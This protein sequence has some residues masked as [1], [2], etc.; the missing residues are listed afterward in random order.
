[1]GLKL[2]NIRLTIDGQEVEVEKGTTVLEAAQQAGIYI[3]TLCHHPDLE[4]YGG[5]R[6]CVI[7]IEGIRG[8]PTACTTPATDGMVVRTNSP[9]IDQVRRTALELMLTEHPHACL[10]CHRREYC[11]P[12]DI[13]LRNVAVTERCV[14]CP[15][16]GHCELQN[17]AR[18]IKLDDIRLPY[19]PKE[20]PVKTDDPLFIRDYNL[21][22]MCARCVRMCQEVR[23]TGAIDLAYRGFQSIVS[24]PFDRPLIDSGCKFCLACVEVCPTA[25]LRDKGAEGLSEAEREAFLVPCKHACP[26]EIDIPRFIRLISERRFADALAVIAEKTPF[27]L[28]CGTVCHHPCEAKCRRG[29]VNE[30]IA[31]RV[32][33]RFLAE[34]A[35]IGGVRRIKLVPPS[36]KRVAIVGAGPAGLT[37]AYYLS[38]L[39]GH[40]ITVLEELPEAGGMLRYGIPEYRLPKKALDSE[41]SLLRDSGVEIRTNTR[42]DSLDELFAQGYDAVFLALG[43]HRGTRLGVE[44]EDSPGVIDGVTF[45]R[46]VNSGEK[47]DVRDKVAVIGGGNVAMDSARTVLRLGAKEVNI[48]YRRTMSEMPASPEEVEG[49]KEEGINMVLLANPIRISRQNGRLQVTCIRMELGEPDASGRR[50]PVPMKGSEFSTDFDTVIAAV[51]QVPDIP[52]PFG[53]EAGRGNTLQVDAET[54]ATNR[55]G[56]FAGGDVVTGPATVTGA[57]AAGKKAAISI[58]R[59]LGGGGNISETLVAPEGASPC[60]GMEEDFGYRPRQQMRSLEISERINNFAQVELGFNEEEAL[61]EAKRCLK[62]DLRLQIG[63]PK[64]AP[65]DKQLEEILASYAR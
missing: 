12:Y 30:P 60:L 45:L 34:R 27:P 3:P 58:D 11:G 22:I 39:C 5:C 51:G 41:V 33:K 20:L 50:R 16:N 40:S 23:R 52:E 28:I 21:C 32:L 42:V 53:L 49:A 10:T 44:G 24:T 47:V 25:A 4:P 59:F 18:Y 38:R 46:K 43:A 14:V 9:Q 17:V 62:C 15:N 37:A 2:D 57:M 36:G 55:Q 29:E 56:V 35:P 8:L 31:I 61:Y 48:I 19:K 64:A 63:K 26:L 13:C 65:V 7:E 6:L 54:L 1:M